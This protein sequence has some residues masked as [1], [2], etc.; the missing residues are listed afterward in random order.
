MVVKESLLVTSGNYEFQTDG[1]EHRKAR[2]SSSVLVNGTVSSGV[3]QSSTKLDGR[4]KKLG[5]RRTCS[6]RNKV[7][8]D[9]VDWTT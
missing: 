5:D 6:A 4:P 2:F 1:A 9:G 3:S 7:Q 8:S